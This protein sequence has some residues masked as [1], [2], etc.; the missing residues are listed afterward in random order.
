MIQDEN[1]PEKS[2]ES[3]LFL[4]WFTLLGEMTNEGAAFFT[5]RPAYAQPFAFELIQ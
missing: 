2:C 5:Q 1:D 3:C 4:F